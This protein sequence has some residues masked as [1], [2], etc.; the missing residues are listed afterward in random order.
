MSL[1][2]PNYSSTL[3]VI[4]HINNVGRGKSMLRKLCKARKQVLT[5]TVSVCVCVS[6]YENNMCFLSK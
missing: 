6:E 2:Y 1:K 3:V 5:L 4:K